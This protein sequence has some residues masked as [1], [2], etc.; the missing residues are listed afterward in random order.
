MV[1]LFSEKP[2]Q[3]KLNPEAISKYPEI[4]ICDYQNLKN[5][6]DFYS[7]THGLIPN[8]TLTSDPPKPL[9]YGYCS[10]TSYTE[11][12]VQFIQKV[13]LLY[14]EATFLN[15]R[16]DLAEKT[17]HS[18]AEQAAYIALKAGAKKLI[19]GHYSSRYKSLEGF[20][21]EASKVFQP[22]LLAETGKVFDVEND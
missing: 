14:H 18:T 2:H 11:S 7:S 1:F 15:D 5:G 21:H 9:Q 13:D 6:K 22:T 12:I 20:L 8:K 10:D 16:V 17:K 19:L 4:Q 3:R